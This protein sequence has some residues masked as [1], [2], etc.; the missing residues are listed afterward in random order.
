MDHG[1]LSLRLFLADE[2][3]NCRQHFKEAAKR[4]FA[5]FLNMETEKNN[6]QIE[7]SPLLSYIGVIQFTR[8]VLIPNEKMYNVL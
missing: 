7:V 6:L 2:N 8:S 5:I 1:P 3:K 4:H